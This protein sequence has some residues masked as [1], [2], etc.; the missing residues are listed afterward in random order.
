MDYH[1]TPHSIFYLILAGGAEAAAEDVA[2]LAVRH[3]AAPIVRRVC[4]RLA[5][6]LYGVAV[7][8]DHA[9]GGERGVSCCAQFSRVVVNSTLPSFEDLIGRWIFF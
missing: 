7:D 8:V 2:L 3:V 5:A 6:T 9:H 4:R 1:D